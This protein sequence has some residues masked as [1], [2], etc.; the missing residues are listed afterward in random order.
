MIDKFS[1]KVGILSLHIIKGKYWMLYMNN[2]FFDSYACPPKLL[3]D[4]SLKEIENVF[5]LKIN[6]KALII[7]AMPLVFIF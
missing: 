3:S 5:F 6:L 2:F 4:L 7:F 1:T